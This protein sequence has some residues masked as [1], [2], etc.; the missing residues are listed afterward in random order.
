MLTS[1]DETLSTDPVTESAQA[2]TGTA[3]V[4]L[5]ADAASETSETSA[6]VVA[7]IVAAQTNDYGVS[8]YVNGAKTIAVRASNEDTTFEKAAIIRGF[9]A[10]AGR[11]SLSPDSVLNAK[12]TAASGTRSLVSLDVPVDARKLSESSMVGCSL[13]LTGGGVSAN[14]FSNGYPRCR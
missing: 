3:L 2:Y 10:P 9:D 6:R 4:A 14:K 11:L 7:G 8:G 5:E 1:D 13:K 12:N